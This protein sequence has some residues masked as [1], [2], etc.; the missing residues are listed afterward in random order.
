[1]ENLLEAY[2]RRLRRRGEPQMKILFTNQNLRRRGGQ[3]AIVRDLASGLQKRGHTVLAYSDLEPPPEDSLADDSVPITSCL[4]PLPFV[5][6]VIHAQHHLTAMTAIMAL[7][8][9]PAVYNC[10]GAMPSEKQPRHP[11]IVR[12]VAIS[13]TFR[14]RMATE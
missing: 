6:D 8:G 11:R 7:P 14:I 1:M 5:P 3:Q 10:G 4:K 12:Y 13:P 2:T 9:V